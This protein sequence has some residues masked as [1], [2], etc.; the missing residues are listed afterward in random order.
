MP[1]F[2]WREKNQLLCPKEG[3][4]EKLTGK[5]MR[6]EKPGN[7]LHRDGGTGGCCGR[8]RDYNPWERGGGGGSEERTPEGGGTALFQR[9]TMWSVFQWVK[10]E[11]MANPSPKKNKGEHKTPKGKKLS[12]GKKGTG[13]VLKKSSV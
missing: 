5:F 4:S 7:K 2:L 13:L 12:G 3:T 8:E 9:G 1:I 6:T 11:K 10:G